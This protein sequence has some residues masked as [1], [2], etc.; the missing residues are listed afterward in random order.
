MMI[1]RLAICFAISIVIHIIIAVQPLEF[2]TRLSSTAEPLATVPV[3]LV[4][5]PE[6]V[7]GLQ[8]KATLPSDHIP[9]VSSSE[10]ISFQS[11]GGVGGLYLE[12]LKLRIFHIWEYPDEAIRKGE[13]GKVAVSFVLNDAGE[14]M[15]MAV[16]VSSG[17]KSLD[18]AAMTAIRK[19]GPFG[20]F[21]A[22]IKDKTMKVTGNFRYVLDE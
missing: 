19:A 6:Y 21:T 20:S 14:V 13:Q 7:E 10:G 1:I 5:T 18:S 11:E 15:D 16:L 9:V 3:R 8:S 22:D 17:S 12:K 4:D 2:A